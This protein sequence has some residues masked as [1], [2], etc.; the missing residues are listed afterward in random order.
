MVHID[1]Q[2]PRKS[3]CNCPFAD[4]RRVICKHMVALLFTTEPK[5]AEDFL[6][7]VEEYE[8]EEEAREQQHYEDLKKYVMGL[9]KQELQEMLIDALIQLEERR[10]Y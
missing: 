7:E 9:S 5:L 4:G 8:A 1:K 6:K 2:H 10:N 3:T